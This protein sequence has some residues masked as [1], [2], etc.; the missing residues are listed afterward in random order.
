MLQVRFFRYLFFYGDLSI[1]GVS[2]H[3]PPTPFLV[4]RG[5]GGLLKSGDEWS[6]KRGRWYLGIAGILFSFSL[7]SYFGFHDLGRLKSG[8]I[9][10]DEFHS[11]WEWT[12]RRFDTRWFGIQSVYNY[13]CFADYLNH[14][15]SIE[16]LK[17]G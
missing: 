7:V 5:E 13:Y 1:I 10:I 4:N 15:Y 9:V 8:R 16:R 14:F 6:L 17:R 11:N 12:D 2:L 3:T